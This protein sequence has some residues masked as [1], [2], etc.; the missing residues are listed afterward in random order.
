M[1]GCSN[2]IESHVRSISRGDD[3]LQCCCELRTGLVPIDLAQALSMRWIVCML[4]CATVGPRYHRAGLKKYLLNAIAHVPRTPRIYGVIATYFCMYVLIYGVL[5]SFLRRRQLKSCRAGP[6]AINYCAM[7][8][9]TY[10][11]YVGGN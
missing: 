3:V 9:R 7:I 8:S 11:R 5:R 2:L 6:S 1:Y 4:D 10:G